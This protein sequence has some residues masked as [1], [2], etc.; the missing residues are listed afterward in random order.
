VKAAI[1]D[2]DGTLADTASD[3]M[4]AGNAT[5]EDMGIEYRM[6]ND[7]DEN[8]ASRGGKS[9]IR[10]GL[11]KAFG[12]AEEEKVQALYHN[13]LRNYENVLDVHSILYE[14]ILEILQDLSKSDVLLGICTNKPTK[15]AHMLLDRLGIS[16]YFKVVVGPDTLGI[17]KPNPQPLH[18]VIE[19]IGGEPKCSVLVG[20]TNTDF[21]TSL[22]ADIPF[23]LATYGHGVKYQELSSSCTPYLANTPDDIP[24][25][26][27]K[28]LKKC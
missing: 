19:M 5:F 21:L 1:F 26:I 7:R 25:L 8:I 17:A 4:L 28:I 23:I 10:H 18:R 16:S 22:A 27:F 24:R 15:Q 12:Y 14:G 6:E 11:S 3:L 2:L 9:T 20:D 13:F